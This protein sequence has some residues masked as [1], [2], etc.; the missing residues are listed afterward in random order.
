MNRFL[1]SLLVLV[2]CVVSQ[3]HAQTTYTNTAY[4]F[5]A[6]VPNNWHV[7]AEINNDRFNNRAIIDWG[8]PEVYSKQEGGNIENAVTITAYKRDDIH[9]VADLMHLEFERIGSTTVS[10]EQIGTEPYLSYLII[11]SRDGL[12]YKTKTAFAYTNGIG[13]IFVFT[14]TPGT[15]EINLPQF[16]TLLYRTR[17]FTPVDTPPSEPS[18][19][20]RYD[21]VYLAKTVTTTIDSKTVDIYT[22]IRFYKDG[23]VYTQTVNS[24]EAQKVATWFGRDGSFERKG[25]YTIRGSEISF[26]VSNDGLPD[27]ALEGARTDTYHGQSTDGD[28]LYLQVSLAGSAARDFWFDFVPVQ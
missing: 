13:Y 5:S 25:I 7:Y 18:I 14:A 12:L 15:Y 9:N 22:F 19:A 16:D 1:F 23:G 4:G 26:T 11:T 28:K 2:L 24:N 27:K 8:L 10:R 6:D 21:G 3:Q 17:F 20:V